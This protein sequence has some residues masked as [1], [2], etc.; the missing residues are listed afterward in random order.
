M[1]R[2]LGEKGPDKFLKMVLDPSWTFVPEQWEAQMWANLFLKTPPKNFLYNTMDISKES[3]SWLPGTDARSL[4]P[5]ASDLE[6]LLAGS[7][8][9]ALDY[10]RTKLQREPSIVVLPDGPYGIPFLD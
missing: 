6:E 1:M 9:W 2:L 4:T 7:I 5:Q 10:F 3:F 8:G